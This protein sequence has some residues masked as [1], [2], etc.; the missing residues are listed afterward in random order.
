M[1]PESWVWNVH[2]VFHERV[3]VFQSEYSLGWI[4][5]GSHPITYSVTFGSK[6][7]VEVTLTVLSCALKSSM[8]V[9]FL[10]RCP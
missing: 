7:A 10:S 6:V 1:S 3:S 4:V 8:V 9:P 2:P 5:S